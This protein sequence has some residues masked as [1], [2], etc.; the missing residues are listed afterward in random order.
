MFSNIVIN[1]WKAIDEEYPRSVPVFLLLIGRRDEA[2]DDAAVSY[3]AVRRGP[4][5][6][7]NQYGIASNQYRPYQYGLCIGIILGTSAH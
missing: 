3:M 7:S 1:L 5:V 2:E 6:N 4:N